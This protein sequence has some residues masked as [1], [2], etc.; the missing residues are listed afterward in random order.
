VGLLLASCSTF[1]EAGVTLGSFTV[2]QSLFVAQSNSNFGS[3]NTHPTSLAAVREFPVTI[4]IAGIATNPTKISIPLPDRPDLLIKRVRFQPGTSFIARVRN[5]V[6][7]FSQ[8]AGVSYAWYGRSQD[9]RTEVTLTAVH[10]VM[11]GL[12]YGPDFRYSVMTAPSGGQ[13][14]RVLDPNGFP[15]DFEPVDYGPDSGAIVAADTQAT[16]QAT[17]SGFTTTIK[18]MVLYT[19][20]ALQDAGSQSAMDATIALGIFQLNTALANSELGRVQYV[21][22]RSQQINYDET[23]VATANPSWTWDYRFDAYRRFLQSSSTVANLRAQYNADEVEMLV[24]DS[25]GGGISY[26]QRTDCGTTPPYFPAIT[27]CTIGP[28]YKP[29]AFS[30]VDYAH[31]TQDYIFVHEVGHTLG[32]DHDPSHVPYNQINDNLLGSYGHF[33]SN[34]V[35]EVMAYATYPN[36]TG[37]LE[38]NCPRQLIFSD[39][40]VNFFGTNYPSGRLQPEEQFPGGTS[41]DKRY[42][43]NANTI[44]IRAQ[45]V[46]NFFEPTYADDTIFP[47]G[48]EG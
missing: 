33:I 39:P 31:V 19:A 48:F 2:D 36:C 38:T 35:R 34:V 1:A 10:G 16:S 11:A 44:N 21:L 37:G 8:P 17:A 46:A 42:R 41:G 23:A 15:P 18:V 14:F 40:N 43:Y 12:I 3:A 47:D 30:V 5:G 22:G 32:A 24:S 25:Q 28:G 9:D 27:G 6:A 29:F 4:D 26:T 20:K 7:P 13:I 45:G